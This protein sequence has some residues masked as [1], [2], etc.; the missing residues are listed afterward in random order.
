M[1]EGGG[2]ELIGGDD[3]P[4]RGGNRMARRPR[5]RS[6]VHMLDLIFRFPFFFV[7][8]REITIRKS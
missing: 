6:G 2:Q 7:R 4:G 5:N 1:G 3:V 8:G